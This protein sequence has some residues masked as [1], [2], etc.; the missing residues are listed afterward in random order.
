MEKYGVVFSDCFRAI[1]GVG[2]SISFWKDKWLGSEALNSR[3]PGLFE[4]ERVKNI[5]VADR[6]KL[7]NGAVVINFSWVRQLMSTEEVNEAQ[8]LTNE[9]FAAVMG[10]GTDQWRWELDGSGMFSVKSFKDILQSARFSNL[11]NNF[12]WNNWCPLKINFVAWRLSLDRLPTL[13]AL[14]HRNVHFGQIGC[15]ICDQ[16]EEDA[17][18]LFVSCE[19]AQFIWNF[20]S[21]WCKIS[22]I[23]AFCAKDLL[24]WHKN[25]QG[26]A[27]WRKLTY[28]LMQVSIWVIW[29]SRNE[30]VFNDKQIIREHVVNEIKHLS[31]LWVGSRSTLKEISWEEWC[32]FDV[33][34]KCW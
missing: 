26:N 1:P 17:D 32:K 13:V 28:A 7:I 33:S 11:G 20:L 25:V 16:H 27:K 31:Y 12:V 18:H 22:N 15:R 30:L 21:Q 19:V 24:E 5:A 29:R 8:R 6:V 14:A 4:L 10:H 2:D 34:R 23:Y 9:L 3:F